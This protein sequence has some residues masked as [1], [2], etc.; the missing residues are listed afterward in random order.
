MMV[1]D[2]RRDVDGRRSIVVVVVVVVVVV[3]EC[4][5][6]YHVSYCIPVFY[7]VSLFCT[8]SIIYSYSLD[9]FACSH[10]LIIIK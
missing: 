7:R 2:G 1:V 3:E 5:F 6:L 10:H 9:R 8:M 4:S